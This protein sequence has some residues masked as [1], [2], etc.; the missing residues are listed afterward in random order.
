MGFLIF[1]PF[2]SPRPPRSVHNCYTSNR[3]RRIGDSN[4]AFIRIRAGNNVRHWECKRASMRTARFLVR[5][6]KFR[7][8]NSQDRGEEDFQPR[9]QEQDRKGK[10]G[11]ALAA[12]SKRGMRIPAA[13][14]RLSSN[15]SKLF[16]NATAPGS[17]SRMLIESWRIT[18]LRRR[19]LIVVNQPRCRGW[20]R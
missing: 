2:V 7:R 9:L 16:R 11:A 15:Y 19:A 20:F 5:G 8:R 10:A 13:R 4:D 12:S 18:A 14:T 1:I 3:K 17:H 6:E